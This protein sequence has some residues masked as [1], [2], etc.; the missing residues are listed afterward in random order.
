[1]QQQATQKTRKNIFLQA[2]PILLTSRYNN[3]GGMRIVIPATFFVFLFFTDLQA[4]VLRRPVAAPYTSLGAYS[5]RHNDILSV[6]AN[7]ASLAQL[8]DFAAGVYAER[9]F[10]LNELNNY[11]FVAGLPTSSGN[12]AIG[13]DYSGFTEFN[14]TKLGLAYARKLGSKVDIGAR[15]NY[16]GIR[17]AGYGNDAAVSFE[18]G[19]ILHL[20]DQLHT[21][22]Y[23][24]NP[25]GGKFGK[26]QQEKISS[27]YSAGFGYD[28]SEKFLLS[29]EIQ[30]EEDQPVNVN[31]GM[32]YKFIPQ[33]MA[34]LGVSS[35]TSSLWS[36]VG[37]LFNS[38]RLDVSAS[39]HQQLGITPGVLLIYQFKSQ[40]K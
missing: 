10:L 22:V 27:V 3:V 14:E 6:T 36:G 23:V 28:A 37:I 26:D 18:T 11:S 4:Q 2:T 20:T 35:A 12:F 16:N 19:V 7:A 39:F 9:R 33:L 13:A 5:I 15:F 24:S 32:Q 29:V 17:I 40:K 1:M 30:K 38:F 8:N 31:A 34:R 25:V 21:G